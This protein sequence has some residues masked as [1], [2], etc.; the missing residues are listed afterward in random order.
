MFACASYPTYTSFLTQV[1]DEARYNVR[2]LRS[3]PSL[4]IWA[5][6]NEDYQIQE[7]H[8]LDYDYDGDKDPQSWLKSS[9]PA[10]YIYEHLLP[11][12]VEEEDPGAIYHPSSPW[13]DGKKT[14]DPAVGDIHQWN[15]KPRPALSPFC[16]ASINPILS[17]TLV[18]HG[19]MQR[20]QELP[21]IGGRFVSEFGMEAYPHVSTVTTAITDPTQQYPGSMTMDYHN[22]A[23]DHERRLLTYVAENFRLKYDLA[24]FTHLTQITQADTMSFAYRSW[25]RDWG[26]AGARKCG[27]VLVWQ[28]NDCWPTMSWAVVDYFRVKKPA[29]YTIKRA[30]KPLAVGVA[31]TFH[32][33]TSGH[34]DPT[35]AASDGTFDVWVASSK[36]EDVRGDVSVRFVS[37]KSGKDVAAPVRKKDVVVKANST[38]EIIQNGDAPIELSSEATRRPFDMGKY[39]PFVIHASLTM[40]EETL[41]TDTAWPHPIKYLDLSAARGVKVSVSPGKNK[42]RVTAEKPV[43]GFVFEET[44]GGVTLS[45]NGFDV[46]PGEEVVVAVQGKLNTEGIKWTYIGAESGSLGF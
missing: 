4:I 26:S 8:N 6:N 28:L 1:E 21:D 22:R 46:V 34:A 32:D 36:T 45:D 35:V 2:R 40:Q 9:F 13:G 23:T 29:F 19:T 17:L 14:S 25:R 27:G 12:V 11:K 5:G 33:W 37:I 31:R 41:S 43:H 38:T 15:G 3:H 7:K 30:L 10:R 44:R 18:W 16:E 42:V 20:Y 39:D 24:A